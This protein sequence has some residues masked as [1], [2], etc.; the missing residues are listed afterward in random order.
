M[1]PRVNSA[2]PR[3]GFGSLSFNTRFNSAVLRKGF[4]C[5]SFNR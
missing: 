2:V 4:G 3:K 1:M 5:L